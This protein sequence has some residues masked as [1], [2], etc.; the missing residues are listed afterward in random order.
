MADKPTPERLL[1]LETKVHDLLERVEK[2]EE[3]IAPPKV[4]IASLED[5]LG[6]GSEYTM[7]EAEAKA[8]SDDASKPTPAVE[9]KVLPTRDKEV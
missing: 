2:L 8:L 1:L 9:S 7:T 3:A 5:E 4:I 6:L